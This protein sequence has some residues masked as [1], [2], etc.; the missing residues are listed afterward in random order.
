MNDT[1]QKIKEKLSII[2]VVSAYVKLTRAGKNWKGLSPFNKE[3]TPSFF[4][5][6]D[7]GLYHCFSSGKGGDMFT[8]IEEIEN[9]DF[10]GA[11]AIL[12]E[13]AGIDIVPEAQGAKD[14]RE[15]MYD[16]LEVANDFF[17]ENLIQKTDAQDY[18]ASRGV[19]PESVQAW[20]LG[21]AP[22]EW[23]SLY[24][25]LSKK[26]FSDSILERAGLVK[27]P[28]R[29]ELRR[30]SF[31]GKAEQAFSES[32]K[33]PARR[34]DAGG[35][36]QSSSRY[37]DRFRGRIMFPIRDVSGRVIGF[38]GRIFED[39]PKHPQAKYLN[40]P[41]T[42][43]FDKSR[44]LYGLDRAKETIRKLDACILV[45]GQIDLILSHQIGYRNTVATSGTSCTSA[46]AE[47]L[48][49]HS[50][51]LLIAYDGDRAGVTA[52]GRAAAV[53]LQ[54]GLNVKI[55][56]LPPGL[57]PADLAQRDPA[58]FKNTMKGA[59]HVVDF[60]LAYLKDANYDARTYR[61]EVSRTVLPYIAMIKNTIDQAHFIQ[62]VALSLDLPED[63]VLSEVK[64][65][66]N[67]A[68]VKPVAEA[69]TAEPFLSRADSLGRLIAALAVLFEERGEHDAAQ[70]ARDVMLETIGKEKADRFKN[71][72]SSEMRP[73]VFEADFFLERYPDMAKRRDALREVYEDFKGEEAHAAYR[74]VVQTLRSA[75]T[76]GDTEKADELMQKLSAL[77]RGLSGR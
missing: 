39:D 11:L 48:K 1:V 32:S 58:L 74:D 56:T 47:I 7:R 17:V 24:E 65:I 19:S 69:A 30:Q 38:S 6:P 76:S 72:P 34:G 2:D 14:E 54:S 21:Y 18:L 57:D 9:V 67:Q 49:R 36:A 51:N 28:D 35:K 75:E 13:K 4:V 41:E 55:S 26:G 77:A 70:E 46:H 25:H 62:R 60:Y 5:S 22:N 37:Y 66:G 59:L 71:I 45:E 64:K 23:R 33:L 16:A 29:E 44:V 20:S 42:S 43:V 8:F 12:A 61:R 63:A 52:A 40:S 15:R 68:A 27:R 31:E 3:K 10:K 50:E 73:A 53:A